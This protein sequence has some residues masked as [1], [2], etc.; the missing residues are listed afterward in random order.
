MFKPL[1]GG[2]SVEIQGLVCQL[3]P[4]GYVF[5]ILTNQ[6]EKRDIIS[7]SE[8]KSEQYWCR[9]PIPEWYT[10]K[11]KEVKARQEVDPE[12]FDE[13]CSE[14]EAQEWDRRLNG[15]WVMINGKATYLTGM[16]YLY[17]QW[18]KI[19]TGYPDYWE[20]DLEY[21]YFLQ[22]CLE[23][24]KCMGMLYVTQ[25]RAGK[26]YKSGV[27]TVEYV[28]R[29][30]DANGGIQ[31][32]TSTDAKKLFSK[33]VVRPFKSLPSFFKP[34]YDKS[35]GT[36]PTKELRFQT[37]NRRGKNAEES[38]DTDE[39]SSV[40]DFQSSELFGYDGQKL[41]RYVADEAGKT[42]DVNIYD[43]H[44]VVRYCMLDGQGNVLGKAL[45][46]TTVEKS[47]SDRVAVVEAFKK[48][49]D[50]SNK[51]EKG[52][53][54]QTKT[55]LYRYFAPATKFKCLDKFG[56]ANEARALEQIKADRETVKNNPRALSARIR[57]DPLT[58]EEAFRADGDQCIYNS[59][60]LNDQRDFLMW[61][62][63]IIERGN[64]VWKDGKPD[65]KVVWE[66]NKDGRWSRLKGFILSEAEANQVEKVGG[67]FKPRHG[68]RFGS[69][70]DPFDHN[71]T[72]DKYKR[73]MAGSF[74]KQKANT[75]N[76]EDT[77]IGAY[78]CMYHARPATAPLF[79]EDM[80]KQCFYFGTPILAENNKPGIT[81][82]FDR[83]GY[84][85][86]LMRM[87]GYKDPGIPSTPGNKQT[88]SEFMESMIEDHCDKIYFMQL[89]DQAL[90]FDITATKKYDLL[91]AALWTEMACA[92]TKYQHREREIL[93][94]D[95]L[96][97]RY[98]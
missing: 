54:G 63:D 68:W 45:Y 70:V 69:G 77:F 61:N 5:N 51:E 87:P 6:L 32:K 40:I 23:D 2:S 4:V 97:R 58:I 27:F 21:Y 82:Y 48:L 33:T 19:D 11:A 53:N 89:I 16:H 52:P 29:S 3:P 71:S 7:R 93:E 39:L 8:K 76:M 98:A 80:I 85:A 30:N 67:T 55:G 83:R 65:T 31:S 73:S 81:Q 66:K 42:F 22:Y 34:E 9:A 37:T 13:K 38:L 88:A 18:W 90:I 36:T 79:Y 12:Y 74:V 14:Y 15:C 17:L 46:T 25:R 84:G 91:M 92:N 1:K 94:V 35:Q 50:E 96:F 10:K 26:S 49:W 47:E 72:E 59:E 64:F 75:M 24:P 28:S 57:K 60:K 44:E 56:K 62:K 41:H 43:R 86:F 78:V 95:S 20:A